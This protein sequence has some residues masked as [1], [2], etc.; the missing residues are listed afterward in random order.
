MKTWDEDMDKLMRCRLFS[1]C[2]G[3]DD[4]TK[5]GK[6]WRAC[7]VD[8]DDQGAFRNILIDF[9]QGRGQ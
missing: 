9:Y 4:F 6:H 3:P 7:M 8:L 1:G 5:H 2:L